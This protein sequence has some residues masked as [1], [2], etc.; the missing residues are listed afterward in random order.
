MGFNTQ[1][2]SNEKAAAETDGRRDAG[3]G[4]G[5]PVDKRTDPSPRSS[6]GRSQRL[7]RQ[8]SHVDGHADQARDR[9][10]R[11]KPDLRQCLW[12]LRAERRPADRQPAEPRH[13]QPGRH[14]RLERGRGGAVPS[15]LDQSGEV[16]RGHEH[17][18][19]FGQG[20]LRAV[21]ADAGGGQRTGAAG[22]P[23]ATAEG[24]RACGAAIRSAYLLDGAAPYDL[25]GAGAR[26]SVPV[27]QR[28][29]RARQLHGRPDGAAV[30]LSAARHAGEELRR[31]AQ[32][33]V[34]DHQPSPEVRQLHGRHGA[35]LLSHVAAVRLS[36]RRGDG[37]RSGR[38][39]Q[40]SVSLRRH[41]ARRRL[42]QQLHGLL[43]RAARRRAAVQAAR[44]RVHDER[45]L[46]SAGHGRHRR[47]AHDAD[48][49]RCA[50]L[51]QRG[52]LPRAAAG[53]SGGRSDAK[54]RDQRGVRQ[55]QPLDG[56]RSGP[57]RHQADLSTISSRCRGDPT[58]PHRTASRAAST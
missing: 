35:P 30:A 20:A 31:A 41:R 55:R 49:R 54:E 24:S 42:G 47:A 15:R 3:C 25:A 53:G 52:R 34:P 10:H 21:P 7:R 19:Q 17:A 32:H 39:P 38:L 8:P 44:R 6:S 14:A 23:G 12:H 13:R 28:R 51:G 18:D 50:A 45:Q 2:R 29:D 57:A 37:R 46:P 4:S 58:S 27:D 16:L 11:G 33:G 48:D 56:V 43:Q 26:R 1:R 36:R 40:R 5:Q 22:D 9:H